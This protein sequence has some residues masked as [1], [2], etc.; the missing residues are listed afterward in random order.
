[1]SWK[2]N[3]LNIA[4][5]FVRSGLRDHVHFFAAAYA[6]AK[7]AYVLRD[8]ETDFTFV[9]HLIHVYLYQMCDIVLADAVDMEFDRKCE[10]RKGRFLASGEV[11]LFDN[12][13]LFVIMF[14]ICLYLISLIHFW[15]YWMFIKVII[16]YIFYT[17]AKYFFPDPQFVLFMTNFYES[18]MMGKMSPYTLAIGIAIWFPDYCLQVFHSASRG[19]DRGAKGAYCAINTYGGNNTKWICTVVYIIGVFACLFCLSERFTVGNVLFTIHYVASMLRYT[20][21]LFK[22]CPKYD[23]GE[24]DGIPYN[25]TEHFMLFGLKLAFL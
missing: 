13:C 1:M 16:F 23:N 14:F 15:S 10:E 6:I 3:P 11:S 22:Y 20:Y 25:M 24:I 7:A 21:Q 12:I 19:R 9:L 2:F 8:E 4:K 17:N 5:A 18:F